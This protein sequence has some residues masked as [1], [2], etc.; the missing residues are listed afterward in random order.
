MTCLVVCLSGRIGSG[1]TSLS[2]ALASARGATSVSFGAY[3]R[4]VAVVRGLDATHRE[5]LQDLGAELIEEHGYEWLCRQVVGAA[6]WDGKHDLIVDGIRHAGVLEA[7]R[8]MMAPAKTVLL[9]LELDSESE[10][11][12]RDEGRSFSPE[13]R[14]E[15]EKHS[16][17]RDVQSSLPAGA[18]LTLRA[19]RWI[20]ETVAAAVVFLDGLLSKECSE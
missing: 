11:R 16:T 12:R 20:E 5:T 19:E 4:S 8:S 18:D 10:L 2:A 15:V 1:K 9:H 17:E 7:I 3:V 14:T 6:N 13:R